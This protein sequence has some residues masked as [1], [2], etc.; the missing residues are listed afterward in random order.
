MRTT[1]RT[2]SFGWGTLSVATTGLLLFSPRGPVLAH[3][4]SCAGTL[5]QLSVVEE[6]KTAVA[7][8]R[9]SLAVSGEGST[10]QAALTQLNQRLAQLR[11]LLQP[12]LQ[13][14]LNVPSPSTY[15]R[16]RSKGGKPSFVANTGVSGE[17]KRQ[18]YNQLIQAVGGQPGVRMQGMKSIANEQAETALQQRLTAAALRRGMAEADDTATAIGATRARLLRI[19]RSDA[20]RGPRRVQLSEA[21]RTGFDPGEAPEP[22]ATVRMELLYCLT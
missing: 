7:R 6:G 17:V 1:R 3:A 13:G 18:M 15:P 2:L 10:E 11:Q 14:R 22:T 4:P 9:F 21:M 8:F 12:F 16:S 19:N 20:M 5:L